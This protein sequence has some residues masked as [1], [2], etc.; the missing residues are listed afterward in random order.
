MREH[1]I[2]VIIG[3]WSWNKILFVGLIALCIIGIILAVVFLVLGKKFKKNQ[4]SKPPGSTAATKS[5][6]TKD[7][8]P[9]TRYEP[10]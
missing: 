3:S 6:V 9:G 5:V 2:L 1:N 10:V 7:V 8:S 4:R